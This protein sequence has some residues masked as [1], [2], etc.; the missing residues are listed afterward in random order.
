[1]S[2]SRLHKSYLNARVNV[3]FYLVTLFISFFSRKIFLEK[4]GADFVGLTSTMQNLLGFLNLAELGIGTAMIFSLYEPAAKDDK[5]KLAQL[6]NLYKI[7]YRVVAVIVLLVGLALMP[8]LGFFIKDSGGI[9]NLKLIYLMYVANSVCSYL[10]SYKNSIFLAYQK[11][12]VKNLWAVL[13]D[14]IKTVL[15]IVIIVL[16]RNFILYLLV[17]FVLQFIPNIIVSCKA[18]KEYPYLKESNELPDQEEFGHIMRNVGAMS[19]HKL[20]T[21]I[22]RNTDS[23]LMSSFVGLLSVGYYSNYRLVLS[24][25]SN[26][27]QK[28]SNAF[29][30]SLGN[31][32]AMEDEKRVYSI[33]RELDLIYFFIYSYWTAGLIALFNAFITLCFGPQ[34]CFSIVTVC[35][36]VLEF[37]ISGQRQVNLMFREA[38]GLFWY[39]R[40]KAIVEAAINLTVSL[41][42]VQR[43]GVAGILGGTV[44]SSVCT[45]VWVEPYILM[46]YGI[47][48][49]W[50]EKLKDYFV[51]YIQ[52]LGIVV[53]LTAVTCGWVHFFPA[54]SVFYFLLDGVVYTAFYGGVMYALFHK[55]ME[56][57]MLRGRVLGIV[58][59]KKSA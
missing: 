7:L 53:G 28:F 48:E 49:N 10:L 2:E 18:D 54:E 22:V 4:L 38:K 58:K 23:L 40:Y 33:Y 42:L 36:I 29:A 16:T 20:A 32:G 46:R 43:F 39:D 17:Q 6:M 24:G 15:Q 27:V 35:I 26:L 44:I 30:G 5:R 11:A 13:C 31:L 19:L 50:Q 57:Q 21:V 12:Y 9:E 8:F 34:Y 14:A 45:C 3:F 56:F 52:R 41:A 25:I 51:K 37:Y 47:R 55:S 1:M 59:R